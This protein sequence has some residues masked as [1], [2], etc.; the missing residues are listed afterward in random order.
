VLG[1][2]SGECAGGGRSLNN[3]GYSGSLP[4][5]LLSSG[6]RS[7]PPNSL[8]ALEVLELLTTERCVPTQAWPFYQDGRDGPVVLAL[9]ELLM[10]LGGGCTISK[11]RA[12]LKLRLGAQDSVKS[13][14]LKVCMGLPLARQVVAAH[15]R[16]PR[17]ARTNRLEKQNPRAPRSPHTPPVHP[18]PFLGS[19]LFWRR[20]RSSR[21]TRPTLPSQETASPLPARPERS[22]PRDAPHPTT[23]KTDGGV[24]CEQAV[25]TMLS[26][27][28]ALID[29]QTAAR[30]FP[31]VSACR[32][33]ASLKLQ[34]QHVPP[35]MCLYLLHLAG[36]SQLQL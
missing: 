2:C 23:R 29:S 34:V 8:A 4:S 13:V 3:H 35:F 16:K 26:T 5:S 1:S 27:R 20:R 11:L 18:V 9:C 31:A 7:Q 33:I 14:P 15:A 17:H 28:H 10:E 32:S 36:L 6:R 12:A 24:G 22:E 21:P 25:A 30:D 19:S